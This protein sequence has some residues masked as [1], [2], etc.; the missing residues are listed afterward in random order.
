MF[1][2]RQNLVYIIGTKQHSHYAFH[3][4]Y[5][6]EYHLIN[7]YSLTWFWFQGSMI[8][9]QSRCEGVHIKSIF[10]S[11]VN[12]KLFLRES[13]KNQFFFPD[14]ADFE[15]LIWGT[16]VFYWIFISEF[17]PFVQKTAC[18][19]LSKENPFSANNAPEISNSNSWRHQKLLLVVNHLI[20][21]I[22]NFYLKL[23]ARTLTSV[24]YSLHCQL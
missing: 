14:I 7:W 21:K 19:R 11:I 8:P 5:G 12:L 17:T 13:W 20:C 15:I 22:K 6:K 1:L 23:T 18:V 4:D 9:H 3:R 10:S 2:A 24:N 16:S